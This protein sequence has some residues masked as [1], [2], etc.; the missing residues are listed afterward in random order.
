MLLVGVLPALASVSRCESARR[1][2]LEGPGCAATE[3]RFAELRQALGPV[4]HVGYRT[5]VD[6]DAILETPF[7]AARFFCAQYTLAPVTLR[8][9]ADGP[10]V[11]GDFAVHGAPMRERIEGFAVRSDFG[12]GLFL[13]EPSPR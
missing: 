13:L 2:P 7:T 1:S 10:L 4:D 11:I 8:N 6:A 12:N 3:R 5:D 9:E